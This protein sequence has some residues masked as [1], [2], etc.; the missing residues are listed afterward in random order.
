MSRT[1]WFPRQGEN[2]FPEPKF[3]SIE[4]RFGEFKCVESSIFSDS[5]YMLCSTLDPSKCEAQCWPPSLVG[6]T[7]RYP[8]FTRR[9]KRTLCP[10]KVHM[11]LV[12]MVITLLFSMD[13][14]ARCFILNALRMDRLSSGKKN[15]G[16]RR[17]N[18]EGGDY[19]GRNKK[20]PT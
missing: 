14:R 18:E 1:S 16:K 13:P 15:L 12:Y 17:R 6:T 2:L 4:F 10:M 9:W 8:S 5:S 3:L 7:S 19:P 11:L 20:L